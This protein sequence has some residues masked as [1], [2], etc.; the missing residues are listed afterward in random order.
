MKIQKGGITIEVPEN[1]LAFY[2]RAGYK[3]VKEGPDLGP[4]SEEEVVKPLTAKQKAAL[5]K[6]VVSNDD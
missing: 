5:A 1:D 3:E 2:I 6:K 4:S